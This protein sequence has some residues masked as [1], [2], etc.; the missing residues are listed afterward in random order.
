MAEVSSISEV[1]QAVKTLHLGAAVGRL[2]RI[3]DLYAR[4]L[5]VTETHEATDA[6]AKNL[7]SWHESV[8]L[9]TARARAFH[10]K[11]T[12]VDERVRA[13]LLGPY[14]EAAATERAADALKRRK[15]KMKVG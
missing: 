9:L 11:S 15:R 10:D 14:E 1:K 5:G 13:L 3:T 6:V 8:G 2:V 4:S 12:P 7:E